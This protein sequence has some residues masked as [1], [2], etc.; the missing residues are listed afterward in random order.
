[1]LIAALNVKTIVYEK[2]KCCLLKL[3]CSEEPGFSFPGLA[4]SESEVLFSFVV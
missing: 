4:E 1:M 3:V 2:A